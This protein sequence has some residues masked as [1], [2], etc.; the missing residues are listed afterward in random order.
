MNRVGCLK[1]FKGYT[2]K[3]GTA[4]L[5][6]FYPQFLS[7]ILSPILSLSVP[8]VVIGDRIGTNWRQKSQWL[9]QRL[10]RETSLYAQFSCNSAWQCAWKFDC[11]SKYVMPLHFQNNF[12]YYDTTH[13]GPSSTVLLV[14]KW[15]FFW[16]LQVHRCSSYVYFDIILLIYI[17]S[18]THFMF[19]ATQCI[20]HD[21]CTTEVGQIWS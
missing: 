4:N 1:F 21:F 16:I 15:T 18:C 19:Y 17:D 10:F 20:L 7:L 9:L 11:L 2:Q 3:L 12:L 5:D 13:A 8:S 6:E 14:T